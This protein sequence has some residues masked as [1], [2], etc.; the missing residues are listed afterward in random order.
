[1]Y[2]RTSQASVGPWR[3]IPEAAAYLGMTEHWMRRKVAAR[4]I[5][6]YRVGPKL[7]RF[8]V[9]DLDAFARAGAVETVAR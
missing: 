6:F 2:D 1:M 8:H 5:P 3:D 4:Q 9:D 7:V